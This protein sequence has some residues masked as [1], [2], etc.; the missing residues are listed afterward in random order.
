MSLKLINRSNKKEGVYMR[1][2]NR[3]PY[4]PEHSQWLPKFVKNIVYRH[5]NEQEINII[6]L[7]RDER[8]A[9][10]AD[11]KQN[12]IIKI[13]SR[14]HTEIDENGL[15]CKELIVC[16]LFKEVHDGPRNFRLEEIIRDQQEIDW[17]N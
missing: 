4:H 3:L 14:T 11:D 9:L 12:Y 5:V 7:D 10:I 16:T 1:I 8:I 13:H 17:V 2:I 6:F 15:I